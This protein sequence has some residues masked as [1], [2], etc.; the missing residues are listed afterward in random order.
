M[1]VP[2]DQMA[3]FRLSGFDFIVEETERLLNGVGDK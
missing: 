1:G 2:H 3:V